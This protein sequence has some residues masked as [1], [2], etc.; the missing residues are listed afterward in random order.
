MS[1]ACTAAVL[2]NGYR[3]GRLAIRITTSMGIETGMEAGLT[4]YHVGFSGK[5]VHVPFRGLGVSISG[6]SRAVMLRSPSRELLAG[7]RPPIFGRIATFAALPVLDARS[8]THGVGF[9][10]RS[11]IVGFE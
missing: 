2:T 4:T 3:M 10:R 1:H 5:S 6:H 11:F 7:G 9:G 8:G